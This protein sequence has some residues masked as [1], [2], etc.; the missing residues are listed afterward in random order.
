MLSG[1]WQPV[2]L[3]LNE[4]SMIMQRVSWV[5]PIF[6]PIMNQAQTSFTVS[7]V[8]LD[9]DLLSIGTVNISG[10]RAAL[11]RRRRK[12]GSLTGR[13]GYRF[14]CTTSATLWSL[15]KPLNP[16]RPSDAYTCVGN[17]T[18]IGSD[19]GLSP[20]RRQAITWTNV[21]ILLIGLLGTNFSGMLIQIHTFSFKKIHLK[22]SSGKWRQFVSASMC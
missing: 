9:P 21:G 6:L 12:C 20:G 7:Q 19:N 14:L 17:L 8:I 10:H 3:G 2:C 11:Q 4:L 18:I 13:V 16:L 22:M 5:L 15:A 1:K